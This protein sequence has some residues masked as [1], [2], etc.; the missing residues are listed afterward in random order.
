MKAI[1]GVVGN[2]DESFEIRFNLCTIASED[3]G[4]NCQ[5]CLVISQM[6]RT[7]PTLRQLRGKKDVMN[8][9]TYFCFRYQFC[10]VY[11]STGNRSCQVNRLKFG[12]VVH[13][14]TGD[15]FVYE[16]GLCGEILGR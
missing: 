2:I 7:I 10:L 3:A 9:V 12:K 16:A 5:E 13:D 6:L 14:C 15:L 1:D 8:D 11:M 4:C